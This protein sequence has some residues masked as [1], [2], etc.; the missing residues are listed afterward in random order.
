VETV[1]LLMIITINELTTFQFQCS[2]MH[3]ITIQRHSTGD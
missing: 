2:K 3:G 1:S